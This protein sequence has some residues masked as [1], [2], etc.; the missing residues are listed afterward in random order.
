MKHISGWTHGS[1]SEFF[2]LSNCPVWILQK[3]CA[4]LL[5]QTGEKEPHSRFITADFNLNHERC[6]S[7]WKRSQKPQ[8]PIRPEETGEGET[9]SSSPEWISLCLILLLTQPKCC[10]FNTR[11]ERRKTIHCLGEMEGAHQTHKPFHQAKLWR[12]LQPG[13]TEIRAG[14]RPSRTGSVRLLIMQRF[15]RSILLLS[16]LHHRRNNRTQTAH[17][18]AAAYNTSQK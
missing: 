9:S 14:L 5:R 18:S 1:G 17:V 11:V 16:P 8:K 2:H 4:M 7:D 10:V 13:R 15:K 6:G 12:H 3:N